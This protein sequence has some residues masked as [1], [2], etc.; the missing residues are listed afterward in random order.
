MNENRSQCLEGEGYAHEKSIFRSK[1]ILQ[2][3]SVILGLPANGD[4]TKKF[5]T[6]LKTKG[7]HIQCIKTNVIS[8]ASFSHLISLQVIMKVLL[9]LKPFHIFNMF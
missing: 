8:V 7:V 5:Y 6:H 4:N 1:E 9:N 3:L 2:W